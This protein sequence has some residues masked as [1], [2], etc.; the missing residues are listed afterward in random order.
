MIGSGK[1]L[2]RELSYLDIF[3]KFQHFE[4]PVLAKKGLESNA[5]NHRF[6]S[7][8]IPEFAITLISEDKSVAHMIPFNSNNKRPRQDSPHSAYSSPEPNFPS[9]HAYQ[10]A[11]TS[12]PAA[13]NASA[14]SFRNVSAC[15]RCRLRKN[16]CDQK[17][18]ACS[19]CEKAKVKCVGIDPITKREIPRA[20][21]YYLENR[22]SYL[23]DLLS[24]HGLQYAP[25]EEFDI[26]APKKN[27]RVTESPA[28][29]DSTK[30]NGL[31]KTKK[32]QEEEKINKLV[33]NVSMVSVHGAS[34]NRYLGSTSGI[35]FARVVFA[36]VRSSISGPA[37]S[38]RTASGGKAFGP[39]A[40]A[41]TTMRDSF[42]GLQSKPKFKQAPF[43]DKELGSHLA[44]LYFEYANPQTPILHRGEFMALLDRTYAMDE[45]KRSPREL[46]ML[47][48]VY[49]IGAGV[50]YGENRDTGAPR[51]DKRSPSPSSKRV[52][53]VPEPHHQPEE[54]HAAAM[55]HLEFFLSALP[56]SE[57]PE[58]FGG[59][60]EELQAV[61]LLAS[62][63]L[64]RPVAPG[65]W[66]IIGVA[67]RLAVD[68]GL[69]YEDGTGIEES[70]RVGAELAKG[71][72]VVMQAAGASANPVEPKEKGRRE[73][74]RDLRRRLWWCVYS[75][76][77]LVSTCVGRP[78][79]ITD[80]VITTE[81]PSILDDSFITTSGFVAPAGAENGPSC[82]RVSHHFFR[83]RLLQSEILQVLQHRQAKEARLRAPKRLD[84]YMHTNLNSPFLEKFDSYNQWRRDID[85][86]LW[87]W[88]ETA[89][90]ESQ[91]ASKYDPLFF[92]LNYW[93]AIIM[94]YRQSLTAPVELSETTPI[95]EVM[96]PLVERVK[97]EQDD[98]DDDDD[99]DDEI[100]M[101]VATAGQKVLKIYYQLHREHVVSYTFLSTHHL[102]MAGMCFALR[103]SWLTD[104]FAGIAFLY[105]I[106]HSV[107]VRN[108]LVRQISSPTCH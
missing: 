66:Y 42:F 47:N 20:Y 69:H 81:F 90:R 104:V 5:A 40:V 97:S 2:V 34:D 48:I 85:R 72:D 59:S 35:S 53:I 4:S 46:Y 106:W 38:L 9:P 103:L 49:A 29:S 74:I 108:C 62:F 102:F 24:S 61:L 105:A 76:D 19:S 95:D 98:N 14:S 56:T 65:L 92:E 11:P 58:G 37:A 55:I 44:Y 83:Y 60:L 33:N 30:T 32:Q 43:P 84:Q 101:K 93:Q 80:Q 1:S 10:V 94:L 27:I 39:P 8:C 13:G 36:A 52:K 87:D 28:Q 26:G 31:E 75:F 100:F 7:Q 73:W 88:A 12:I 15:N 16:R 17:L 25:P 70:V 68:L 50:I 41:G 71:Q 3:R 91:L 22:V 23:E 82:K 107:S 67:V 51:T 63:A 77:R 21:V 96:K 79:G 64:L 86:R 18:P 89:P 6:N 45:K 54:Y 99:D 78:L 57:R